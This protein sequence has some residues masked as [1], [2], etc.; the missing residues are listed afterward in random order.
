MMHINNE[1]YYFVG[2]FNRK[3]IKKLQKNVTVIYRN[4]N[5]SYTEKEIKEYNK[6]CKSLNIK[7]FLANNIKLVNKLNLDG[8]YIPSF[9]TNL[10]SNI[11]RKKKISIIGSAH[12]LREINIKNKQNVDKIVIS[13]VFKNTEK[14]KKLSIS[15][16]NILTINNHKKRYIAL[17]GINRFNIKKIKMLNCIGFASISYIRDNL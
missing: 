16:F 9:N 3:E 17:G 5:N 13:P 15:Q 14:N 11:L 12:N 4:Y 6:Y 2:K 8:A 10:N 1:I 7:F